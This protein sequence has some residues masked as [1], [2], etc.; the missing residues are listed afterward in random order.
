MSA[1][2]K[3][4]VPPESGLGKHYLTGLFSSLVPVFKPGHVV[5]RHLPDDV[6][7]FSVQRVNST[8]NARTM[9]TSRAYE[10]L[11]PA[12]VLGVRADGGSADSEI[13]TRLRAA[14]AAFV[15]DRPF[16]NY[17]CRCRFALPFVAP[18]LLSLC[19]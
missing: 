6:R 12:T 11:L 19:R 17:T 3:V 2:R 16:H 13:L 15:G 1:D 5:C 18:R 10:Y 8:F 4:Q 7:V 14:L 9:C